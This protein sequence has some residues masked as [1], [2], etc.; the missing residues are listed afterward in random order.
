MATNERAGTLHVITREIGMPK[1]DLPIREC[2][3]GMLLAE[4]IYSESGAVML[5]ERTLLCASHLERLAAQGH[6]R[7]RVQVPAACLAAVE[8][9]CE[10]LYAACLE[11]VGGL[12][13]PVTSGKS[14]PAEQVLHV[15]DTVRESALAGSDVCFR[16]APSSLAN[17]NRLQTHSLNTAML[18]AFLHQWMG[19]ADD[20]LPLIIQAALLHDIGKT[21]LRSSLLELPGELSPKEMKEWRRHPRLSWEIVH[22]CRGMDSLVEA[23]VATHHELPDGSGYPMGLTAANIHPFA[24]IV[25]VADRFDNLTAGTARE[26][27]VSPFHAFEVLEGEARHGFHPQ[28][29]HCLLTQ[30]PA[31]YV[32]DRFF[33]SNGDIGEVLHIHPQRKSRPLVK[34]SGRYLDLSTEPGISIEAMV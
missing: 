17:A 16:P 28:E 12:F 2:T 27:S 1:R 18:A 3:P 8:A 30:V 11:S 22:A 29:V 34:A 9:R 21:R 4:T 23:I 10:A 15:T 24:R 5:P 13:A 25:A 20:S 31:L 19:H 32:G 7:L 26:R 14:L 33:L 6:A